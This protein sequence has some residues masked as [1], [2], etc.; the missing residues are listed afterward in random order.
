MNNE[1]KT[2]PDIKEYIGKCISDGEDDIIYWQK[3]QNLFAEKAADSISER[4]EKLKKLLTA[5]SINEGMIGKLIETEADDS[6]VLMY[7]DIL[8][9]YS[10]SA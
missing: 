4:N 6:L 2:F 9:L 3:G 7:E 1:A 8:D 5:E 10:D